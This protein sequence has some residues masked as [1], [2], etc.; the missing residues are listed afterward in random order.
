MHEQSAA[1]K[2]VTLT[3]AGGTRGMGVGGCGTWGWRRGVGWGMGWGGVNGE[4]AAVL[5]SPSAHDKMA[6]K[7]PEW[8][9]PESSRGVFNHPG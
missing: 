3:T 1:E 7:S 4:Q 2:P 8:P 5:L 6:N 9:T